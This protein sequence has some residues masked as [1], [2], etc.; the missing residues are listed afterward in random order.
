MGY[1][2]S[3]FEVYKYDIKYDHVNEPIY[4]IPFGDVHRFAP[5]CDVKHWME[6]LEWAKKKDRC[7]FLG[8]G[9]YDDLASYS[10]RKVL[11]NDDLHESTQESLDDVYNKRVTD[12]CKEIGFM[13]G[14]LIGLIEGNHYAKFSD[15]S[16]STQ[17]M[18]QYL[19]CKYLGVSCAIRLIL[20]KDIHHSASIDIYA[21]HG[22]G[23]SRLIGGSLN[24]VQQMDNNIW[25][26]IYLQ[27]HDH[28]KSV[29]FQSVLYL[30][31]GKRDCYLKKKKI[32]YARTGSFLKGYVCGKPSYVAAKM[33]TPSDLG[34]VKI[35]LTPRRS[36]SDGMNLLY[37]DIHVSI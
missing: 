7:Y 28:K 18:C 19:G 33:L 16:T 3:L 21:H 17:R 26:D 8:M 6:F 23:A 2:D 31:Q 36:Q 11:N 34:V 20:K 15:G 35:E 32:M 30:S 14:K 37:T 4:L 27:G 25:C 12:L 5:L 10:E 9:D 22:L 13:K 29:A 1:Q 24:K